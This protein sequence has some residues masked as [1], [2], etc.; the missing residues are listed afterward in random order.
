MERVLALQTHCSNNAI[1]S[2]PPH[3]LLP[4]DSPAAGQAALHMPT[5]LQT[6]AAD[7]KANYELDRVLLPVAAA[8][9]ATH[10]AVLWRHGSL[11]FSENLQN[12]LFLVPLCATAALCRAAPA[13]YRP[14]AALLRCVLL[15]L[16]HFRP[17]FS[18]LGAMDPPVT[19]PCQVPLIGHLL[20]AFFLWMATKHCFLLFAAGTLRPPLYVALLV[21]ASG[22]WRAN[23]AGFCTSAVLRHPVMQERTALVHSTI[24]LAYQALLGQPLSFAANHNGERAEDLR[25]APVQQ[26]VG[27]TFLAS[28]PS[29]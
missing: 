7:W 21:Q 13:W 29:L 22:V 4:G 24:G 6:L 9:M 16:G 8:V 5:W 20:D 2:P 28:N 26:A 12:L 27:S 14:C 1:L 17:V 23:Q 25:A 19:G 11:T 10:T 3:P 15:L 18:S